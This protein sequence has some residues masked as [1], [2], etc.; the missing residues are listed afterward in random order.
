MP[1]ASGSISV[2][3]NKPHAY[4]RGHF[5]YLSSRR[6]APTVGINT[7]NHDVIGLLVR[8]EQVTPGGI[9][10]EISRR[11]ALGRY[12][13]NQPQATFRPIDREHSNVVGTPVTGIKALPRGIHLELR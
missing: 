12:V 13:L 7:K 11:L 5:Q 8:R 6:Q 10:G 3:G 9:N 1:A 2:R 4:R